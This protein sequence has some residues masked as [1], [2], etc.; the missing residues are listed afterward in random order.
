MP[1]ENL[2]VN[3]VADNKKLQQGLT[4]GQKQLQDFG[5]TVTQI[6]GL[7][8]AAF[9]TRELIRFTSEAVKMAGVAQ[10]V[11]AAFKRLDDPNLLNNLRRATQ[12]M[13]S[14]LELMQLAVRA[15]NFKIPL[16]VL[17]KGLE[18][19]TRRAKE[20]GENVDYL[21]QSFVTGV[22][23]KSAMVLDNL[24]ISLVELQEEI[25][26]TGD[27]MTATGNIIDR[28]MSKAGDTTL[29]TADRFA[30]V[31]TN[32]D[33]FQ[34]SLGQTIIE[35]W[36]IDDS[37]DSLNETIKKLTDS[38]S[39][40]L[41]IQYLKSLKDAYIT[42]I[43]PIRG[44]TKG[45]DLQKGAIK[46]WLDEN[47]M[48]FKNLEFLFGGG[49][50][51][52]TRKGTGDTTIKAKPLTYMPSLIQP[53]GLLMGWDWLS[54]SIKE[55]DDVLKGLPKTLEGIDDEF[56]K[57]DDLIGDVNVGLGDQTKIWEDWQKGLDNL[58]MQSLESA[59]IME[60][61]FATFAEGLSQVFADIIT[62]TG[63]LADTMG[64][65]IVDI[66][67]QIGQVLI[68]MGAGLMAVPGAQG[69]GLRLMAAGMALSTIG[70]IGSNI[71]NQANS[72]P[73][74]NMGGVSGQNINVGGTFTI[75]GH[76]LVAA[77][78]RSTTLKTAIT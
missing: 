70:A 12:G 25:K 16:D 55:C 43:N 2:R 37:L 41:M 32:A 11:E 74:V 36:E 47:T 51:P 39:M 23:R 77:V 59:N 61:A 48:L 20:T 44:V 78:G 57:L 72:N 49:E 4:E 75:R 68:M 31:K 10:G 13:V 17:A 53:S 6:G 28:E 8:G 60:H 65:I 24:G 71:I 21:V 27:F 64:M 42:L 67:R 14:D 62:Q 15:D 69:R 18:F 30:Q 1:E 35:V 73:S 54:A 34:E 76:D 22:G 33:N 46:E 45:L 50:I 5:K 38:D 63:N 9:G 52:E 7:I 19:A 29:T 3:L 58:V 26:V 56:I 40:P 66:A